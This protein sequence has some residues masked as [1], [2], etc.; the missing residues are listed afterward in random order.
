[1]RKVRLTDVGFIDYVVNT[2]AILYLRISHPFDERGPTTLIV[3]HGDRTIT[4]EGTLDETIEKLGW[5]V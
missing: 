4:V 5:H 1:M 2:E 3:M